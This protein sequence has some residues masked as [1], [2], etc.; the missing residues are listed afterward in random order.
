MN[1]LFYSGASHF[2]M[3]NILKKMTVSVFPPGEENLGKGHFI[4]VNSG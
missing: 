3:E 1:K 4:N 2:K